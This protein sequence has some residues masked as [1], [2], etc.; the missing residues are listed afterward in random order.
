[1]SFSLKIT[2]PDL[3]SGSDA[4]DC[5]FLKWMSIR[6]RSVTIQFT[7]HYHFALNNNY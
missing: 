1:M 4:L 2:V 6:W 5:A 7:V 3:F